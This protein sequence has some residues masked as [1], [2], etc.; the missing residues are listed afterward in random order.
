[1]GQRPRPFH[2][3]VTSKTMES[4]IGLWN[5][6][7]SEDSL[8]RN[9]SATPVYTTIIALCWHHQHDIWRSHTVV[10]LLWNRIWTWSTWCWS[11]SPTQWLPETVR[12]TAGQWIFLCLL[13]TGHSPAACPGYALSDKLDIVFPATSLFWM[14]MWDC[15]FPLL[16]V[17]GGRH[18][19]LLATTLKTV[20]TSVT[21][22]TTVHWRWS[23][24]TMYLMNEW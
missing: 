5:H 14:I 18:A 15:D 16:F 20:N 1:M 7:C 23:S 22:V 13:F 12:S 17:V 9:L 8:D 2:V 6:P 10:M 24:W 21:R 11:P 4:F 19:T 3:K